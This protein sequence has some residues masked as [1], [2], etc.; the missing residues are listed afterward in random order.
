M[1]ASDKPAVPDQTAVLEQTAVLDQTAVSDK[2][3]LPDLTA[4]PDQGAIPNQAA[5]RVQDDWVT[6]ADGVALACRIWFPPGAGPWPALL[7]RQPYGRAIASTVTYAHPHWYASHGYAV[8][9]Q[10]CRGWGESGG[11]AAGFGPEAAD[12]T[13]T[14]AWLRR[15]SWCNGLVGGYGFSYQGLTQLLLEDHGPRFD[16]L[17]PAMAGLDERQHWASEGGAHWWALQLAWGLQLA[18]LGCRRRQDHPAWQEIRTSLESGRFLAEGPA[19]LERHD[20]GAMGLAWLRRDP[21]SSEG[22][23]AHQPPPALLRQPLLLIGGWHDPYLNGVIDLW[24]QAQAAGGQPLLRIGPWTHLDWG[25]GLDRLQLAFF[26]R[27]LKPAASAGAPAQSQSPAPNPDRGRTPG[28]VQIQRQGPRGRGASPWVQAK[29]QWRLVKGRLREAAGLIGAQGLRAGGGAALA[30]LLGPSQQLAG[31]QIR[32]RGQGSPNEHPL[33]SE[34]GRQPTTLMADLGTG[35]WLARS[36]RMGSGQVWQLHS[37]GLAAIDAQEGRLLPLAGPGADSPPTAPVVLVHDPWRPLP[38]RGGHLGLDAGLVERGDLDRRSDVACFTSAPVEAP[39]EL[40]GRPV[41]EL[42]GRA[43]QPGFDLCGAL[44]LVKAD[45][46]V[47]Q[48][49]TGVGRWLGEGCLELG[50]RR[51]SLQPLLVT[52]Q[53]GERLRLSIG[54]AAWPQIAV[55]PGTGAPPWGPAGAEHRVITLAFQ[56]DQAQLRLEPMVGPA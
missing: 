44:S 19:L 31:R 11:E 8:V 25:G 55:N 16:A 29:G 45:G 26:D 24:R 42:D 21:A 51:L 46:R 36:P 32:F 13:A 2:T 14:L 50:R 20:P 43:D 54:A 38:G 28:P 53:P 10:D 52:L 7:M 4:V 37:Q 40:L 47:L 34:P 49:S 18:A 27:H 17:A 15:Q 39:L 12:G 23:T 33:P 41:L 6:A 3:V 1:A 56:L 9:V 48:L 30:R 22:W 5:V 35:L